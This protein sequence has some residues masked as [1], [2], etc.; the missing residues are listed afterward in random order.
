[1]QIYNKDLKNNAFGK[2]I[3]SDFLG[4]L[5]Y[6][7]D[8]DLLTL[9]EE[10]AMMNIVENGLHLSATAK[11]I[12]EYFNK[13]RESVRAVICRGVLSKPKRAVL[14]DFVDFCKAAPKKWLSRDA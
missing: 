4:F 9:E 3:L 2:K 11:D 8:N 5:K 1:M 7:V 10:Q 13:S 12:A 14:H 6:K